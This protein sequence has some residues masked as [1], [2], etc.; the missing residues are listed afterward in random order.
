MDA[1]ELRIG[2]LV[3]EDYG[4]IYEVANLFCDNY[5]DL[6]KQ[7]INVI[8]RYSF[9]SI[10]PIPLNENWL[11]KIGYV[12]TPSGTYLHPNSGN[13]IWFEKDMKCSIAGEFYPIDIKY[14]HQLQNLYFALTGKELIIKF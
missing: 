8:G 12:L 14:V 7:G 3:W 2:N 4:G 13:F 1:I 5:I 6:K 10:K 9:D 11:F